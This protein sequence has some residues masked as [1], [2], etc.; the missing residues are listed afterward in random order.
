MQKSLPAHCSRTD[1][2]L[3]TRCDVMCH[4]A[5]LL[6][7]ILWWGGAARQGPDEPAGTS[8]SWRSILQ[9]EVIYM[10]YFNVTESGQIDSDKYLPED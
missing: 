8:R 7:L 1:D 10:W 3:G 6:N 4:Y 5:D 9:Q 2:R